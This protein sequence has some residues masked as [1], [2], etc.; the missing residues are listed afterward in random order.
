MM[1]AFVNSVRMGLFFSVVLVTKSSLKGQKAASASARACCVLAVSAEVP[2]ARHEAGKV[3]IIIIRIEDV[4][5][6]AEQAAYF[7][8]LLMRSCNQSH[9]PAKSE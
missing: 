8:L 5:V 1:K 2:A 7:P 6:S 3:V 9:A 4:T